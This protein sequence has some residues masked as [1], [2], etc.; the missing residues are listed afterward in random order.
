LPQADPTAA[1]GALANRDA[2]LQGH[3]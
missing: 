2:P 1:G 3:G